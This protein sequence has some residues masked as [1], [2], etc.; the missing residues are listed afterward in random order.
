MI[1]LK[2]ILNEISGKSFFADKVMLF[3]PTVVAKEIVLALQDIPIWQ[4]SWSPRNFEY[5]TFKRYTHGGFGKDV[6]VIKKVDFNKAISNIKTPKMKERLNSFVRKESPVDL[7]GNFLEFLSKTNSFDKY[8][9]SINVIVKDGSSKFDKITNDLWNVEKQKEFSRMKVEGAY[10]HVSKK[11][12]FNPGD[13]IKP[14]FDK[15]SY[16]K[17]H[18]KSFSMDS[19]FKTIEDY[20]EKNRPPSA[21]SREKTSYVFKNIDDAEDYL[22]GVGS[23]YAAIYAVRP[24]GKIDF[25]D[26]MWINQ[27]LDDSSR[28]ESEITGCS[29]GACELEGDE[30]DS[31]SEEQHNIFFKALDKKSKKYW[32][33]KATSDPIWEGLTK[34]DLEIIKRVK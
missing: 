13:I 8:L 33:K 11:L 12:D 23:D 24:M 17:T 20:L 3:F 2:D 26:M 27:M 32:E 28:L 19:P 29:G 22:K 5:N 21:P 6:S 30:Y 15:E 34:S 4:F 18:M 10:Y 1:K 31:F 9:T 14:Y 16:Q 7:F 25:F